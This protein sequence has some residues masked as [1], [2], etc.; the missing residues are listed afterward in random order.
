MGH[1]YQDDINA[2]QVGDTFEDA[3]ARAPTAVATAVLLYL[4]V[5]P[6]TKVEDRRFPLHYLDISIFQGG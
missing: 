1:G 4:D 6:G 3:A 5:N 2:T